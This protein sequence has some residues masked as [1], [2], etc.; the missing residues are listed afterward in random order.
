MSSRVLRSSGVV[1]QYDGVSFCNNKNGRSKLLSG[2]K[3]IQLNNTGLSLE[4][5]SASA[6]PFL[7]EDR[8]RSLGGGGS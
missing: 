6:E 4:T 7:E 1:L 2:F 8:A 5:Y 3:I